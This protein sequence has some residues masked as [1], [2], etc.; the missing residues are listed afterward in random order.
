MT[1]L[2]M[3]STRRALRRSKISAA[4]GDL[5][6]IA[7]INFDAAPLAMSAV[8][9]LD[10]QSQRFLPVAVRLMGGSKDELRDLMNE[11]AAE[12][13]GQGLHELSTGLLDAAGFF[14]EAKKVC[15]AALARIMIAAAANC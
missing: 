9:K 10:S 8:D 3:N 7:A 5:R 4:G 11:L 2:S 6:A 14:E 12:R 13:D 1:R 15:D